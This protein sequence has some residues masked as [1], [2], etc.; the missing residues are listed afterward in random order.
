[1]AV[2][3]IGAAGAYAYQ[4]GL[5][6]ASLFERKEEEVKPAET[7]A[8]ET[9]L[10]KPGQDSAASAPLQSPNV[11]LISVPPQVVP[12]GNRAS[13]GNGRRCGGAAS[14]GA[15]PGGRRASACT[16]PGGCGPSADACA[17]SCGSIAGR[18]RRRSPAGAEGDG[19]FVGRDSPSGHH[20]AD[21]ARGGG[22]HR[23]FDI[24]DP[25]LLIVGKP[26]GV[27]ATLGGAPLALP[28]IPG[29]TISRVNIK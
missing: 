3:V 27:E 5:I 7:P 4:S 9:T 20:L 2:V 19:R 8:L 6:P 17:C 25:A 24:K 29:G 13:A 21:F 10:L 16:G 15:G 28:L 11:P 18:E 14:A 23:T 26:G 1:V 22:Q 12:C